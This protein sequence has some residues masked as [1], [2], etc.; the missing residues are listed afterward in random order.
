[1]ADSEGKHMIRTNKFLC[2]FSK[3]LG[4]LIHYILLKIVFVPQVFNADGNLTDENKLQPAQNPSPV[5][6]WR[7]KLLH[8]CNINMR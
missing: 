3:V 7:S 4:V 6:L 5:D 1:M 2:C 8:A